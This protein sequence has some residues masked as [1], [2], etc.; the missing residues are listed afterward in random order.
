VI[1]YVIVRGLSLGVLFIDKKEG[2]WVTGLGGT[3][4]GRD[5]E[6]GRRVQQQL[7]QPPPKSV[8]SY[9]LD[10]AFVQFFSHYN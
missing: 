2:V 9:R 3:V 4:G 6:G 10:L 5:S 1:F 8:T 7:S